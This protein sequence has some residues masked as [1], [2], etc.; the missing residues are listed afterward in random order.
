M[1]CDDELI[2]PRSGGDNPLMSA[3][4][5]DARA[6]LALG[7]RRFEIFRLDALQSRF[8]VARLPFSLKVL[9]ENLLRTEGNGSV[10]R[11][12]HRGARALGRRRPSPS[13]E[14][15]FTPARVL[16]AGLHRRAGRRRPRRDARRDRRRS[17]ATR[18]RS[19]RSCRPSS[20][21][22]TRCRSTTSARATRFAR[23]A[24]REFERNAERYAFLRWG[25]QA[26][27]RFAVVP[28][29]TGIVPPG[30]PRVPRARRLRRRPRRRAAARLPRHAR[31]HRLAHDDGQ[32]PRRAR[33]GRRRHRGRGGDARPADVDAAA[34][35]RRL[36]PARRAARG[37]DGDRPRADRDRDAAREGRRRQVRRVLR[38]RPRRACR[39][40]TARRSATCRRSTARPARSSRSTP[41]RCATCASPAA[42]RSRSSSSRPTPASR[43]SGTTST[44]RTP[45]YSDTLELDLGD[46]EPSLAGP[47]RPQDRV[48][49]RAG[50]RALPRGARDVRRRRR[51]RRA[52]RSARRARRRRRRDRRDHELHEHLEPVGDGRRRACSRRRRSSAGLTTQAVGQDLARA[53]LA[54]RHRVPRPGRA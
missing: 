24:E 13:T 31:R 29:D 26:F 39:S 16:H 12:R 48:P 44:P 5:F 25:Q 15:A 21:S 2:R 8:D 33:L 27:E 1:A 45:V 52:S 49:L 11:R 32:R 4:S 17:A 34:A 7:T 10:T 3:N 22:T 30:Q 23:N 53:R 40:P 18:R 37:R 42:P 9:L 43:A 54:G 6:E 51:A 47:R 28:P 20:S 41:R 50:A 14:I 38:R 46:V 35:G 36:P 19:T